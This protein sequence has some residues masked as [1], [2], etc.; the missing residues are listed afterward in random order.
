MT[1]KLRF[2]Y[3]DS[4]VREFYRDHITFVRLP[5][6]AKTRENSMP[7][8]K[9]INSIINWNIF[10]GRQLTKRLKKMK[11][12]FL[13]VCLSYI[14]T[15]CEIQKDD[16]DKSNP[17]LVKAY[18]ADYKYPDGF[19]FESID[20]GSVYYVNT[21]SVKPL[22]QRKHVW[23]DLATNDV[24]EARNW[25]E[26][27]NLYSSQYRN[28]I[29][30]RQTEKFFEF[31]RV[32]PTNKKDIVLFRAHKKDYFI[33][34]LDKFK[35]IDTVGTIPETALLTVNKKQLIEYLWSVG[36]IESDSKVIESNIQDTINGFKHTIKSILFV[37][38]D[39]GLNDIIYLYENTF[40]INGL[41]GTITM[42]RRL[43]DEIVG[44]MN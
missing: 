10:C 14:I 17:I 12:L 35:I 18:S 25:T 28:L 7:D 27:S 6:L 44:K 41:N 22:D 3:Q 40:I 20:S 4:Y 37:G 19:Y 30:E 42:R 23:I 32:S 31:K 43:L 33:P 15:G 16:Y 21:V 34:I 9:K 26:Y 39:F 2:H 5:G 13:L 8:F 24:N 1:R 29:S 38:G 11:Q 36:A